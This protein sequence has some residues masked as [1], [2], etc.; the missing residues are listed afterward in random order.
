MECQVDV[1]EL[2]PNIDLSQPRSE[3]AIPTSAVG[4][5]V[6]GVSAQGSATSPTTGAA[7]SPSGGDLN[8]LNRIAVA[9]LG[10]RK[11][12]SEDTSYLSNGF[13]AKRMRADEHDESD[14]KTDM[15]HGLA[16]AT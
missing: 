12:P 1:P 10:I 7:T 13:S 14:D 8:S 16:V 6:R 2:P 11:H 9:G 5:G 3:L 15:P 4:P